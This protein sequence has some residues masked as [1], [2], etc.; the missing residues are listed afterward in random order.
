MDTGTITSATEYSFV[1]DNDTIGD[2]DD[3]DNSFDDDDD[4]LSSLKSGGHRR[5]SSHHNHRRSNHHR[6]KHRH[7]TSKSSRPTVFFDD[8]TA[9][10]SVDL[11]PFS[12]PQAWGYFVERFRNEKSKILACKA[13]LQQL[14]AKVS[15]DLTAFNEVFS[16]LIKI[17]PKEMEENAE[18][19]QNLGKI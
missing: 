4:E 18:A 6:H 1:S 16:Q 11:N 17:I 9:Y 15:K 13:S 19:I 10:K 7:S 5:R 12:N 2:E 3:N 14:K 8:D